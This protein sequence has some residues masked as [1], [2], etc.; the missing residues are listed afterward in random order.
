MI[1]KIRLPQE[2]ELSQWPEIPLRP[3]D[4]IYF[5]SPDFSA[6][7][8]QRLLASPDLNV[9]AVVSNPDRP[10]G[11]S[12]R[13][14]P[15]PVTALA[16]ER[17]L[18]VYRFPTLRSGEAVHELQAIKADL[19]V[20][21]AYGLIIPDA[22][23]QSPRLGSCN[24]H[25]SLLPLLRGASPVQTAILEGMSST[26]WTLQRLATRMDA[27]DILSTVMVDILPEETAG[28]L[29][30]RMLPAGIDLVVQSLS[31]IEE[32]LA[33][34]LPQDESKA[35]YCAKLHPAQAW[36]NWS[37]P[38]FQLHNQ[39]RGMNPSP[40]ARTVLAGKADPV[41]VFSSQVVD[42]VESAAGGLQGVDGDS[43]ATDE[44]SPGTILIRKAGGKKRLLV[45]TG[46]KF[47]EVIEL[48]PA[49][50]RRMM[51]AEFLNGGQITE[52][53]AFG[54]TAPDNNPL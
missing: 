30:D 49:G 36:L 3:V 41:L 20:V 11:R 50:R 52:G 54:S 53:M 13:P 34:A 27:G 21:F 31:R 48:Q 45:Q 29:M 26:G 12:A 10:Q 1:A 17:G 44:R 23:F 51:A 39:I 38:A 14:V 9:V 7:L 25:G 28:E 32:L 46:S 47:L 4:L 5:G 43:A 16:L 22:V 18:P 2:I 40:V 15:T 42:S 37:L 8:L 35:T 24:L 6:A 19:A 33:T